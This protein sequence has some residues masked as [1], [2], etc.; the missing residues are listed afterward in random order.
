MSDL[1]SAKV[2]VREYDLTGVVP[3][4]STTAACY[5]GQFQWGPLNT[6]MLIDNEERL[7]STFWGPNNT[8]AN[9]W[10]SAANFLAYGNLLWNV[11]VGHETDANPANIIRNATTSN[12]NGFLVKNNDDYE[13]NY[14][15]GQLKSTFGTG[16]WI[17]RYPGALGNSL[18]VSVCTSSNTFQ[19]TLTGAINVTANTNV[20][21]GVGT[22]FVNEV[23]VGDIIVINGEDQQVLSVANSTSLTLEDPHQNGAVSNTAVRFWEYFASVQ[24]APD[25]SLPV[26]N[27]GG[28]NDEMHIVVV[29]KDG[30]WT[31][32]KGEVLEVFPFVSKG[33]DAPKED[34]TSNYYKDIINS[35][36][37]YIRWAGHTNLIGNIGTSVTNKAFATRHKPINYTFVGGSD[38]I[39][40]TDA[41][42]IR[43]WSTFRNKELVT[44]DIVIG[45]ACTRTLAI[46]LINN[47]VEYRKDC[48]VF[49][50]P[51]RSACVNNSGYE[52]NSIISY[53][54]GIPSS[55]YASLDCNW[56]YQYD[57]Y[58]DIYRWLPCNPDIAGIHVRSDEDR[59]AWWAA[60]GLN[61]GQMK[62]VIKF[63]WNPSE[64]DRDIL[65]PNGINPVVYFPGKGP[66]LWGQKTLLSKPSAFDRINVRRLF[67]V[68]ERAISIAAQYFLF[69]FNDAITRA[70]FVNMVEPY[71]RN[72]QSRRGIYDF[73]VVCDETNNTPY[74]ID[75]NQL[76]ADIYVKPT[77]VA[78]FITL[79]FIATATGIEFSTIVGKY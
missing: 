34:G 47:L 62:N 36:S 52:L 27:V 5:V 7:H 32:Q 11:R 55:S 68:M 61:R 31:G 69:E 30:A 18:K 1:L 56:K 20:V 28:S 41:D 53:R 37:R 76:I 25:T 54:N 77:R 2:R 15:N 57:R 73:K 8:I 23:S 22:D 60:A 58:N 35:T 42:R 74:V 24:V 38:G 17:A 75:T 19:S 21:T 59:D 51:I 46:W 3:S 4:V 9:D 49:L 43:G 39:A 67:L 40:V 66:Y 12:S 63:A 78:E 50:S 45:G 64:S 65:Y 71:L 26:R 72:I 16:D 13:N 33:S 70:Q 44:I 14:A 10:F 48:I 6:Q 79:N 29:D